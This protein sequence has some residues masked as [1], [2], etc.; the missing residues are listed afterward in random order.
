MPPRSS[1]PVHAASAARA[2]SGAQA[3]RDSTVT[4]LPSRLN[5][6][7]VIVRGLTADELWITTGLSA[8]VGLGL[9]VPLAILFRSLATAPGVI[10]IAVALGLFLGGGVI[11]RLKRGRPETWVYRALERWLYV[12]FPQLCARVGLGPL[13]TRSGRWTTRRTRARHAR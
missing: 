4:F 11:R 3:G 1:D 9:G 8:T 12:R 5:R 7:P 10:V 6:Q 13:I 2:S